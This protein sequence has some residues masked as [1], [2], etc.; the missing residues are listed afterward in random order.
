[1]PELTIRTMKVKPGITGL[2]QIL[3]YRGELNE[4]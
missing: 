2:A 4:L 3:G 1:M